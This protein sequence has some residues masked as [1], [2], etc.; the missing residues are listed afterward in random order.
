MVS[1]ILEKK[2][3]AFSQSTCAKEM[4]GMNRGSKPTFS[5][6]L[7]GLTDKSCMSLSAAQN[8]GPDF[9]SFLSFFLFSKSAYTGKIFSHFR[10]SRLLMK[11]Y[12][13]LHKAS[14]MNPAV[15]IQLK[16]MPIIL[17]FWKV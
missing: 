4:W 13:G 2:N 1:A 8:L 14:T 17:Y 10:N 3:L 12:G 7:C 15:Q 5:H 11:K 9:F 16:P 6:V